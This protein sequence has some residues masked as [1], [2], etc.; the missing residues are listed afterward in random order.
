MSDVSAERKR[1]PV[2]RNRSI[3]QVHY[4]LPRL[5]DDN[6]AQPLPQ[7]SDP[8]NLQAYG[9]QVAGHMNTDNQRYLGVLQCNNGTILKPIIKETQKR[10]VDFYHQLET[11]ENADLLE[12]KTFVPKYYGCRKFTYNGY[13]QDYIVL[14]NLCERML[15]PCIMDVKIGR[16]TWDPLATQEKILSE[17][18]KY[19]ACRREFAFCIPGYQVYKLATGKLHKYNKDYG[20]KLQGVLVNN[21]LRNFLN[22]MGSNLCRTLILQFLTSLWRI[23]R[24]A[25]RQTAVRLYSSSLLLIYDAAKLRECCGENTDE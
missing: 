10:E 13:E 20:K 5:R 1:R 8:P 21:A 11:T 4:N 17:Q 2:R 6:M 25:S 23:H 22:G 14:E 16:R 24:W 7:V 19:A 18:S 12:L 9:M 15:E 3:Y